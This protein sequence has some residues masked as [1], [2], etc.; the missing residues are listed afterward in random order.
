MTF[1]PSY[2]CITSLIVLFDLIYMAYYQFVLISN[3]KL[4]FFFC[5]LSG[6]L[7][8]RFDANKQI[9]LSQVQS[10]NSSFTLQIQA[11]YSFAT[12]N[13]E[14]VFDLV[15][16]STLLF[17]LLSFS[18]FFILYQIDLILTLRLSFKS[19]NLQDSKTQNSVLIP[20]IFSLFIDDTSVSLPSSVQLSIY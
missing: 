8:K 1:V 13:F 19:S 16:H 5:V 7:L 4:L 3:V 15:W 20:S 6:N 11:K 17:K 10:T 9:S 14:K 12:L 2:P 18:V